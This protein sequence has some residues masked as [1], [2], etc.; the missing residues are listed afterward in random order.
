LRS[1]LVE[2]KTVS[3]KTKDY[4][5]MTDNCLRFSDFFAPTAAN[6]AEYPDASIRDKDMDRRE[7]LTRKFGCSMT[8]LEDYERA[9]LAFQQ[10]QRLLQQRQHIDSIYATYQNASSGETPLTISI[11]SSTRWCLINDDVYM[12]MTFR[13]SA[14]RPFHYLDWKWARQQQTK[15]PRAFLMDP[16]M[17]CRHSRPF[18]LK[19]LARTA[20]SETRGKGGWQFMMTR[21]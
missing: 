14:S 18:Q 16:G 13:D 6:N 3:R 8:D 21:S 5:S 4:F 11:D 20:S 1:Q 15:L 7:S 10:H 12:V 17:Y 2:L 19:F 9:Y